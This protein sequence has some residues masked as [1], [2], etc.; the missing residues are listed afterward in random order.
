[1]T[2]L[3]GNV[4]VPLMSA[5][6]VTWEGETADAQDGAGTF[7]NVTLSPKRLTAY[8]DISKQFLAQTGTSAENVIREDLIQAINSKLEATILGN[9]AGSTTQPAGIFYGNTPTSVSDFGDVCDVE[10]AIEE[11]NVLGELKYIVSP[12]TKA[13][14]RGGL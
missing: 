5:S 6:N 4:Q 13:V 14:L 3:V 8:I 1:M 7:T 9:A 12:K 11:A 2:G 10:A